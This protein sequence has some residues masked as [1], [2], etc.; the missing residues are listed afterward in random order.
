MVV[1]RMGARVP[2][3]R[4]L[5]RWIACFCALAVL[6]ALAAAGVGLRRVHAQS[7]AQAPAANAQARLTAGENPG[8]TA[9]NPPS[10]AAAPVEGQPKPGSSDSPQQQ[11]KQEV[12]NDCANLLKLATD[13]KVEVDKTT[14]DE[15]SIAVVRK[16]GEIEQ[17]A[18][19]VK[20]DPRLTAGKE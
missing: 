7:G 8:A 1:E 10:V 9:E 19:K 2:P 15:L 6:V 17:F 16:A 18:R 11:R 13:L 4:R 14:K 12:A 5:R 3:S 20:G